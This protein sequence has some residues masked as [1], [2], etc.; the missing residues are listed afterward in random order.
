MSGMLK[1]IPQ[2][3]LKKSDRMLFVLHAAIGD[4]FYLQ[5]CFRAVKEHYP[6][7][8]IDFFVDEIRRTE[9][10]SQWPQLANY[11]LYDWLEQSPYI[12]KVY[13]QTYNAA[14]FEASVLEAIQEDYPII[15]SLC[16]LEK[17][18]YAKLCRRISPKGF[19]A[20]QTRSLKFLN[21]SG[22]IAFSRLNSAIP[23]YTVDTTQLVHISDIFANWFEQLFGFS[24]PEEKRKPFLEIPAIWREYAKL[25]CAQWGVTDNQPMV[26]LNGY[27][28]SDERCWPLTHVVRLATELKERWPNTAFVMNVI[29]SDVE[30]V[31]A[32]LVEDQ[33]DWLHV[34]SAQD[35]F[36]QLPA[37]LSE[38]DL[39]IS[40][41]TAV[42][43]L[44]NG[45]DV[46]VFA[47]MRQVTPEWVPRDRDNSHLIVVRNKLDCLDK[48]S[49]DD[50]LQAILAWKHPRLQ[51]Q[52]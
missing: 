1:A 33:I 4:F 5:N 51:R 36:Y 6:N 24:I 31:R 39:I 42:M 52:W 23:A 15:V 12:G 45:V 17:V 21:I 30:K 26:F 20:A 50:V 8:R 32:F 9:D 29:P 47:L 34:F 48:L 22:R 13:R 49:V 43:H 14:L 46:P 27:S 11:S 37:V 28:K 44:A 41:E 3:V 2:Q 25:Q 19:I 16:H 38:C 7:L 40:V 18:K 35:N 10:A